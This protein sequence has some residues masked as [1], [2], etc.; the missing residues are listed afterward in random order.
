MGEKL[1]RDRIPQ[2]IR[3]SG[4]EPVIRIASEEEYRSRLFDKLIEEAEELR[5]AKDNNERIEELADVMEVMD[6]IREHFGILANQ[7]LD[8]KV[9]K[10]LEK[11]GFGWKIILDL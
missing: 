11:G 10:Y 9:R 4:M 5:K 3:D 1:V 6:A 7:V 8:K 2:I